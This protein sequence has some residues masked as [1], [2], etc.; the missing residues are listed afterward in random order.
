M[1]TKD[2]QKLNSKAYS[3]LRYFENYD[4]GNS[5]LFRELPKLD[6]IDKVLIRSKRYDLLAEEVYL[7]ARYSWILMIYSGINEVDLIPGDYLPYPSLESV[8]NLIL[9]LDAIK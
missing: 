5:L 7:D 1:Y 9:N 3:I 4:L 8:N 2:K 6:F